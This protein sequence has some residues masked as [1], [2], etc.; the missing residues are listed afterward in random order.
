MIPEESARKVAEMR[1]TYPDRPANNLPRHAQRD[2]TEAEHQ[3]S[4]PRG[5]DTM[6]ETK[7]HEDFEQWERWEPGDRWD[8]DDLEAH[9]TRLQAAL[10]SIRQR[11]EV[12]ANARDVYDL[13]MCDFADSIIGIVDRLE[14]ATQ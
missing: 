4:E 11:A 5:R 3:M 1:E 7:T 2:Y 13:S 6:S 12:V 8:I 9:V 10:K 14:G